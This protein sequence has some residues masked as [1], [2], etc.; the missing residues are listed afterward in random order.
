MFDFLE[1]G[2]GIVATHE[3]VRR[4]VLDTEMRGIDLLD[5]L[6]KDVLGLCELRIPPRAVLVVVLQAQHN[7]TALGIL[8]RP[9]Q[10]IDRARDAFG[11]RH[12]WITLTARSPAVPRPEAHRQVDRSLLPLDLPTPLVGVGVCEIRRKTDH[13]RDLT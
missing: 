9:P 4:I 11:S 3:R 8:E 1:E 7:I 10:G 13:R 2:E 5:D 6:E 12:A